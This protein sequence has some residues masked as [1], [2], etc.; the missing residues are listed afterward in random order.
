[1]D[2]IETVRSSLMRSRCGAGQ[3]SARSYS[4]T[5]GSPSA[6]SALTMITLTKPIEEKA[7]NAAGRSL[8]G[9]GHLHQSRALFAEAVR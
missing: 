2:R 6:N 5:N 3:Q 8:E 7:P 1:M 9:L 4:N